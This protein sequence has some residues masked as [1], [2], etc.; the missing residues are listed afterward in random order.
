MHVGAIFCPDLRHNQ[1]SLEKTGQDHN[2]AN[3]ESRPVQSMEYYKSLDQG[4]PGQKQ[5]WGRS[6]PEG[7]LKQRQVRGRAMVRRNAKD[8]KQSRPEPG[9]IQN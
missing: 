5:G 6:W 4:R 9:W 1:R 8:A 7:K 3:A 2:A